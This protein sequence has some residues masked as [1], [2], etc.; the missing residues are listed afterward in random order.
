MKRNLFILLLLPFLLSSCYTYK[1]FPMGVRRYSYDGPKQTAY[2]LN[3]ELKKEYS[4]LKKSN[5][6]NL[7]TDSLGNNIV[8]IRLYRIDR[9][10]VCGQPITLSVITLGQLP[11]YLPDRYKFQ[12]DEIGADQQTSKKSYDF[13]IATRY[14]FWDLFSFHK[15]FSGKAGKV[16]CYKYY[17]N[18]MVQQ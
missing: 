10:L 16:L 8:R 9:H 12:F 18:S 4:I 11:V 2:I 15:D 3:P 14:W 7:S 5:I 13:S 1:I 17:Q 6:Y